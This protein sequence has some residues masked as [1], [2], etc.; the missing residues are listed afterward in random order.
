M[1]T[2]SAGRTTDTGRFAD[3]D[4]STGAAGTILVAGII[5]IMAGAFQVTQGLVAL[6]NDEFYVRGE[7]YT[8]QF[9]LTSWGWIHLLGGV[10][11]VF[12]GAAVFRGAL[13]ARIVAVVLAVLS[14]IA[15]FMWLPY[16][17]LWATIII[18]FD[19]LIVWAVLAHPRDLTRGSA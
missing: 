9:D 16:Y 8:F 4:Y 19:V 17:P 3:Q 13:W 10:L 2:G 18:A 7:E 15:N 1:T 14:A 5:M 12:A 11:L 6:L